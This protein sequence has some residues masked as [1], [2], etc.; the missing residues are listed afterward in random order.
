MRADGG[1]VT[2]TRGA[3]DTKVRVRFTPEQL[4][5]LV[6]DQATIMS[7][8]AGNTLEQTGGNPGHL[9]DW[10]LVLRAALDNTPMYTPGSIE[11]N[12]VDGRPLDA[13]GLSSRL[14]KY[15]VPSPTTVRIGDKI[16]KALPFP[17]RHE[18]R[19]A[20]DLGD[21]GKGCSHLLAWIRKQRAECLE[22][23]CHR[24][25]LTYRATVPV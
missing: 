22:Q 6:N 13:R 12:D 3:D 18:R 5:D 15:E 24:P 2:V 14:R 17:R 11:L 25:C 10:W 9:M 16:Q 19:G 23:Q 20:Y 4:A 8:W 1:R 21:L 7:L